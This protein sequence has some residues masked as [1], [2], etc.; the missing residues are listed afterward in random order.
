[1]ADDL[2]AK[3]RA[4]QEQAARV[5]FDWPHISGVFEKLDEEIGELA[6]AVEA[7]D[8]AQVRRELGDLMFSVVNLSRFLEACASEELEAAGRR[9][10]VR[11]RCMRARLEDQGRAVQDCSLEELDGIWEQVKR[12]CRTTGGSGVA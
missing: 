9:F 11:F 8:A 10:E 7:G 6:E 12:E 5:G 3:T 2:L 1:M 4:L